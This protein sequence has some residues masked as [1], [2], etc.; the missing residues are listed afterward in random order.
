MEVENNA[1]LANQA[2]LTEGP[3][4]KKSTIPNVGFGLFADRSYISK[5]FITIYGGKLHYSVVDG[6]YVLRLQEN[7]PIYVDGAEDF[8]PSEKGRWI[9]HGY[10]GNHVPDNENMAPIYK[11]ANTEFCMSKKNDF[12]ICYV[13][14]LRAIRK[15]EELFV[16][17][18]PLYW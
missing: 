11:I 2:N 17:Y 5:E 6:E 7:P 4:I 12:P 14:A 9:N 3:R 13:R 16:D 1:Q 15:D 10:E 18:G 8:H